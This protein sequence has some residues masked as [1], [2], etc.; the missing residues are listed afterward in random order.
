MKKRLWSTNWRRT[1][2]TDSEI[3]TWS[4]M[5]LAPPHRPTPLGYRGRALQSRPLM[6]NHWYRKFRLARR[7][8]VPRTARAAV[9]LLNRNVIPLVLLWLL[10]HGLVWSPERRYR[11]FP[12]LYVAPRTPPGLLWG[13]TGVSPLL[14]LLCRPSL[15]SRMAMVPCVVTPCWIR[16]STTWIEWRTRT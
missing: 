15:V 1:S 13:P 8:I 10:L 2:R 14:L 11:S 9:R 12:H 5:A 3:S 4:H 7:P 6:K 16:W